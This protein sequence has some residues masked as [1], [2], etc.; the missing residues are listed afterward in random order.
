MMSGPPSSYYP[1]M[2]QFSHPYPRGRG[3]RS[4]KG[5]I[6]RYTIPGLTNPIDIPFPDRKLPVCKRCKKIYKTRELCRV[7]DGHTAVPWNT[8]YVCITLEDSCLKQNPSGDVTLVDEESNR[9]IARTLSG[10]TLPLRAKR[11]HLNG[12]KTPICMACK[13]K[14]YTRHH[15]R[16][17]QQHL[18]LPWGTVYISLG[19]IPHNGPDVNGY[20]ADQQPSDNMSGSPPSLTSTNG[21]STIGMKRSCDSSISSE[22]SLKKQKSE[23]SASLVDDEEEAEMNEEDDLQKVES[24]KTFLLTINQEQ[25]KLRWL[26]IDPLIPKSEFHASMGFADEQMP[27]SS[28][29]PENYGAPPPPGYSSY[30]QFHPSDRYSPSEWGNSMP[31][32]VKSDSSGWPPIKSEPGWHPNKGPSPVMMDGHDSYGAS[33]Y[34]PPGGGGGGNGSGSFDGYGG[35]NNMPNE[36]PPSFNLSLSA[37]GSFG[38]NGGSGGSN[39]GQSPT[40]NPDFYASPPQDEN[41]P[42]NYPGMPNNANGMNG[43]GNPPHMGSNAKSPYNPPSGPNGDY[44]PRNGGSSVGGYHGADDGNFNS[45]PQHYGG[46]P[47]PDVQNGRTGGVQGRYQQYPPSGNGVPPNDIYGSQMPGGRG[48]GRDSMGGNMPPIKREP[49]NGRGHPPMNG[50]PQGPSMRP[51]TSEGVPGQNGQGQYNMPPQNNGMYDAPSYGGRPSGEWNGPPPPPAANQGGHGSPGMSQQGPP[52]LQQQQQ[53]QQQSQQQSQSQQQP[54]S[55]SNHGHY[56]QYP[57]K[58]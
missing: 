4:T 57:P 21:G 14:N 41:A 47:G 36:P 15:C 39:G 24:S 2:N 7:R 12:T 46:P 28:H 35:Y 16:E 20:F 34:G 6:L 33:N 50:P 51:P 17:K 1:R 45:A 56:S 29:Y 9:F 53:Q 19:A 52:P 38:N 49:M 25:C 23:D 22:P 37:S 5:N 48:G 31:M 10:P 44:Y 26:E 11:G 54:P 58:R 3:G 30:M 40:H 42:G 8:T 18:Q 55:I 27:F 43:S 32:P 13:D